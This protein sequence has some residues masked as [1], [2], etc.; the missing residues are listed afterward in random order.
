LV[1]GATGGLAQPT[2]IRVAAT[3]EVLRD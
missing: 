3:G 1:D 2:R